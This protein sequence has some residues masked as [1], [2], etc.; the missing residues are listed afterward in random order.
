MKSMKQGLHRTLVS[1]I[2]FSFPPILRTHLYNL[3]FLP[4][5]ALW[6]FGAVS[7]HPSYCLAQGDTE[8]EYSSLLDSRYSS[9]ENCK[10]SEFP[11][12][13]PINNNVFTPGFW[14]SN[15]RINDQRAELSFPEAAAKAGKVGAQIVLKDPQG[16]GGDLFIRL[17]L[18]RP[19]NLVPGQD[20]TFLLRYWVRGQH[21]L[22]DGALTYIR[23]ALYGDVPS[24]V[25][26]PSGHNP[27]KIEAVRIPG[28]PRFVSENASY[29]PEW[30]MLGAT[31][32]VSTTAP[33][34]LY[35]AFFP[36]GKKVANGDLRQPLTLQLDEVTLIDIT[37][38]S[39]AEIGALMRGMNEQ[40]SQ[41]RKQVLVD[42]AVNSDTSPDNPQNLLQ[43]PSFET[44]SDYSW[45]IETGSPINPEAYVT[46][47]AYQGRRALSF[48]KLRTVDGR[49]GDDIQSPAIRV[50]PLRRMVFSLWAKKED[51]KQNASLRLG[52]INDVHQDFNALGAAWRRYEFPFTVG[53]RALGGVGLLIDGH[54]VLIDALQLEEGKTAREFHDAADISVALTNDGNGNVQFI[55]SPFEVTLQAAPSNASHGRLRGHLL[56]TDVA[57]RKVAEQLVDLEVPENQLV[58]HKYDFDAKLQGIFNV[59]FVPEGFASNE[60]RGCPETVITRVPRP[61]EIPP[62][63]SIIGDTPYFN[64]FNLN[65]LERLG[66]KWVRTI[67]SQVSAFTWRQI[68]KVPGKWDWSF[69][70]GILKKLDGHKLG[71]LGLLWGAPNFV[72]RPNSFSTNHGGNVPADLAQWQNFAK[73]CVA[74]YGSRVAAWE[75]WNEPKIE[76]WYPGIQKYAYAGIKQADPNAYALGWAMPEAAQAW[77]RYGGRTP[78]QDLSLDGFDVHQ[79][80]PP[81][82]KFTD[83]LLRGVGNMAG[84]VSVWNTEVGSPQSASMYR[85]TGRDNVESRLKQAA[86][87]AQLVLMH[88]AIN[89]RFIYYTSRF[90]HE[91]SAMYGY[92]HGVIE[93]SGVPSSGGVARAIAAHFVDGSQP[94][95]YCE[96]AVGSGL[97]L[98]GAVFE[99]DGNFVLAL[100]VTRQEQAQDLEL[101]S[102]AVEIAVPKIL[103]GAQVW[104]LMGMPQGTAGARRQIGYAPTYL[105]ITGTDRDAL[106]A[107]LKEMVTSAPPAAAKVQPGG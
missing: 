89:A 100:F 101:P 77:A 29:F 53:S 62:A 68:E 25:A 73:E 82:L 84:Q 27:V 55:E 76:D 28:A 88:K 72:A 36:L 17:P 33:A 51:P 107:A 2:N 1:Y 70:D 67:P 40:T 58:A 75:V 42:Q 4:L 8:P 59:T 95:G 7:I 46:G 66:V 18:A 21:S 103:S 61:L 85:C 41:E 11:Y 24:G 13:A 96:A 43:N 83:N 90:P 34:K 47:D 86:D 97:G 69:T 44:D 32:R 63:D 22:E 78:G 9:F 71:V 93:A 20:R 65:L 94:A 80:G 31:F 57:G 50:R 102:E 98:W 39:D 56:V 49:G 91:A 92:S 19:L 74:R 60:L 26:S 14:A 23:C 64:D 3:R 45:T 54:N 105:T 30:T 48:S 106:R 12:G 87:M 104:D 81:Y 15:G 35:S 52:V 38:L 10:R 99:R 6:F 37:R 5:K 16:N 79:Y